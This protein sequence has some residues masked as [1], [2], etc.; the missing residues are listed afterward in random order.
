MAIITTPDSGALAS[1]STGSPGLEY[2]GVFDQAG[3]W[4]VWLRGWGNTNILGEGSSDSVHAGLNGQL[5]NTADSIDNFPAGWNWSNSTRDG[6]RASLSIPEAGEHNFNLWMREDGLAIDKIVLTT[7]STYV[8]TGVGPDVTNGTTVDG[9]PDDTSN[10]DPDADTVLQASINADEQWENHQTSNGS[11]VTARH[12]AGGVELNGKLYVLGG[13][14]TRDVSVFDPA[15]NSWTYKSA[16]PIELNHYQPVAWNDKIWVLG[17]FTGTFP[18]EISVADIYT[19]TPDTDQWEVVGSIPAERRRGAAGT[20]I[21]NDTI[22]LVGGNSNGHRAGAKPWFDAYNPQT[23]QWQILPDA[24]NSRDHITVATSNDKLVV[25]AGRQSAFPNTFGNMLSITNVYD[26]AT[27]SWSTAANIPTQRAG[28]MTVS[29][30]AD[31]IVIGGES[32]GIATARDT[33]EAYNVLSNSW[34]TLD[35]LG[36]GKH[37]GAAA[38]LNEKIHVVSGSENLGG[39]PE[40]TSHETL[41]I[42]LP[43]IPADTTIPFSN[44]TFPANDEILSPDIHN[45]TG[46]ASNDSSGITAVRVRIQQIGISTARYWDGKAWTSTSVYPE[47]SLNSDGSAWTLADVD[48]TAPGNYRIRVQAVD[49]AGNRAGAIDNPKTDFFVVASDNTIPTAQATTPLDSSTITATVTDITGI[50]ADTQSNIDRVI[51]RVQRLR[52]SPA[53]YWNG[54]AWTSASTYPEAS[55]NSDGSAWTLPNVD[56][57]VPGNYRIRVQAFDSA[58]NKAGAIDNPKTDFSVSPPDNTIPTAQATTPSDSSAISATVTDI[59]GIT[60]DTQSNIDRVIV[61]VQRLRV[62]PAQYWNGTAWTSA[63]TYP[64]ASLNSDGNTWT[65]PNVDLTVPGNYR[66]RVQ[67]FDTAGNKAGA[68]DNPKTDFSVF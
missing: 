45:I 9:N 8:P 64:E 38:V 62:S 22:Y 41:G 65:L 10:Q 12:E 66:I 46:I 60:A 26:F 28:T 50:A 4:Y 5:S 63:S 51:V 7:D 39:A 16:A 55:L 32:A 21:H 48:L 40:S 29:V 34:H 23:G 18:D 49:S 19:Y 68:L 14:G 57:T 53:Q 25:A 15:Q 17:A 30:G 37:G 52:V 47:A 33:V 20:V 3:T 43:D 56:L 54:T 36:T 31:V 67:A 27:S 24:P 2:S 35:S 59:T 13:R 61:R 1:G 6:V 11:T 44:V 58:G 42:V